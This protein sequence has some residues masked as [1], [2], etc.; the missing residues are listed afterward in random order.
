[1]RNKMASFDKTDRIRFQ[2]IK[3]HHSV[4]SLLLVSDP[5][6]SLSDCSLNRL[7]VLNKS[8]PTE[9]AAAI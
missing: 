8:V 4:F 5:S 6:G 7:Q 1:M 2:K 3:T 9:A